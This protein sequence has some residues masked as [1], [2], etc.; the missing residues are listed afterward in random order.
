MHSVKAQ[1]VGAAVFT[2]VT[3][4]NSQYRV[5]PRPVL[6]SCGTENIFDIRFVH[7]KL[8]LFKKLKMVCDNFSVFIIRK[9]RIIASSENLK[10]LY[11]I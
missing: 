2:N 4:A 7:Y 1:S 5:N 6:P 3:R 8:T 9:V 10:F 11:K